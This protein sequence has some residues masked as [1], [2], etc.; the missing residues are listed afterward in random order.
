MLLKLRR[1]PEQVTGDEV[2]RRLRARLPGPMRGANLATPL[3]D[4][5]IDSL[6]VVELLCLVDDE[7]GV[8]FEQGEF[9]RFRTVGHLADF[10]CTRCAARTDANGR[11]RSGASREGLA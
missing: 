11:E 8:R 10:V 3:A 6:D 4:L 2:L 9:S 7:F 5:P 1:S